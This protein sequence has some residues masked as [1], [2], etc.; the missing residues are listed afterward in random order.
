MGAFC[1]SWRFAF[2]KQQLGVWVQQCSSPLSKIS[3]HCCCLGCLC[4]IYDAAHVLSPTICLCPL[5]RPLDR[6]F[7]TYV[8]SNH[9]SPQATAADRTAFPVYIVLLG[10]PTQD[11]L[12]A[13]DSRNRTSRSLISGLSTSFQA[14]AAVPT[15]IRQ[16][17]GIDRVARSN[18]K[19]LAW[20]LSCSLLDA[21]S[22]SRR[23]CTAKLSPFLLQAF[24]Y[25]G[26]CQT[27]INGHLTLSLKSGTLIV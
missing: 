5:T 26:P 7:A 10:L 24:R 27:F 2:L 16:V 4:T 15:Q 8:Q 3:C 17:S 23:A 14:P 12:P 13:A 11:T 1:F 18:Q 6:R 21:A 20:C 25:Y 22:H 9:F 19:K